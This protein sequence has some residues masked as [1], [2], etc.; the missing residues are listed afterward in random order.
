[1][2]QEVAGVKQ[3]VA[4]LKVEM[5]EVK[6][7]ISELRNDVHQTNLDMRAVKVATQ[8]TVDLLVKIDARQDADIADVRERVARIEQH[9][10]FPR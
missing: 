9:F 4:G 7:E 10:G 6:G 3:E 8:L 1:M 2:K 5:H